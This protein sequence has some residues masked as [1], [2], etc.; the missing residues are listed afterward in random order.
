MKKKTF[1]ISICFLGW[2]QMATSQTEYKVGF[3]LSSLEPDHRFVSLALGGYAAPWEGR[4][5]LQWREE[6]TLPRYRAITG[7]EDRIYFTDDQY[8]YESSVSLP[9]HWV[10]KGEIK[11]ID[12][13]AG[14]GTTL[15]AVTSTGDL[16]KADLSKRSI[17][18][19]DV[20]AVP[21]GTKAL[22][23]TDNRLYVADDNG[24]F[25]TAEAKKP[26]A[27]Q[28]GKKPPLKQV[29][30]LTAVNGALI[31]LTE[32]GSI[33]K[34]KVV[35]PNDK[36]MMIAYKNGQTVNEDM[37]NILFSGSR[38]WGV[39]KQSRLY[40]S[41]HRSKG[42]LSARALSIQSGNRSVVIVSLDLVGINDTFSGRVKKELYRLKG[43]TPDAVFINSSHTHFAPVSQRWLTWQEPN[44]MPDT[45]YLYQVVQ[46]AIIDAVSQ[47]LEHLRPAELFFARG[48]ATIGYN[49]SLKDHP[50]IY[51]DAVDV[52]R[53]RYTD[54]R[55]EGCLFIAACHP[56]KSTE[57]KLHFT[58]SPNF[59]GVARKWIEKESGS[60]QTLFLQGTAGDINP[61]DNTEDLSGE[62]LGKEVM[63]VLNRPMRE[64]TGPVTFHLDTVEVRSKIDARND[65]IA[66]MERAKKDPNQMLS[67]RNYVWGERMLDSLNRGVT[68]MAMPVYVHT[69]NIGNWKLV[70]L[71]RE[72]TTPYGF[73]IKNLW[74]QSM[75]SVAGYTN[76]VSSYLPTSLHI[77]RKNYEGKD[78]FYWYGM[79]DTFPENI[80]EM[81]INQI[82]KNNY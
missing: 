44:R 6:G 49:R 20:G 41:E 81:I 51:D 19:K 80:E 8:L 61:I 62:K 12:L 17:K 21:S 28:E 4:F 45:T 5:T 39:D 31:A 82:K 25:W 10:R 71:S 46:K 30:S 26:V 60:R 42:E 50:E 57:G 35:D 78:S 67:E 22:A 66:F 55:S 37:R 3:G 74:P 1:W 11:N 52:L 79:P 59:P 77:E 75:V 16:K 56:V 24:T 72:V 64:I 73:G 40:R 2:I 34:N 43:I 53:F 76:D 14:A 9:L 65:I 29:I 7:V 58:I 13:L 48:H 18:W 32:E 70:G 63:A 33:L 47:S 68:E 15:F 38:F 54:D 27:W 69:I 23:V 36:W